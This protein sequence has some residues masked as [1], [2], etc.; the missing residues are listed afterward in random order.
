[1]CTLNRAD[2]EREMCAHA[3][4]GRRRAREREIC[5]RAEQCRCIERARERERE[6]ERDVCALNRADA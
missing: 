5:A 6:R 2:A 4:Q 3:E 1:M